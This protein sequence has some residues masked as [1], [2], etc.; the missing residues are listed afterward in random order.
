MIIV[1]VSQKYCYHMIYVFLLLFIVVI[2]FFIVMT[3]LK[4]SVKSYPKDVA[5]IM[6]NFNKEMD[7]ITQEF[8]NKQKL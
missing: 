4:K 7:R 8:Y 5:D 2:I 3:K 1:S 6:S